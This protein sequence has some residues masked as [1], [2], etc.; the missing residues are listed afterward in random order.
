MR[1]A[2]DPESPTFFSS[3]LSSI[4]SIALI[5][6]RR[7]RRTIATCP[8]H[9]RKRYLEKRSEF[10]RTQLSMSSSGVSGFSGQQASACYLQEAAAHLAALLLSLILVYWEPMCSPQ[11]PRGYRAHVEKVAYVAI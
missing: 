10:P 5:A 9:R 11:V 2:S 3:H 6:E 4:L 7:E 8:C 1:L